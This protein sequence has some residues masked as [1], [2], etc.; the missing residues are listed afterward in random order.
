MSQSMTQEDAGPQSRPWHTTDPD[1][2]VGRGHPVGDFMEAYDWK[3]VEE[4]LGFLRIQV[5]LPEQVKNP[6]GELFGGFA[7]TYVDFIALHAVRAG[8]R[9]TWPNVWLATANMRVDYFAPV[10]DEP[11]FIEAEE[12]HHRSRTHH[13]QVRFLGAEDAMLAVA[14]VTLIERRDATA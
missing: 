4:R 1:R 12:L 8:R 10:K 14:Q 2:V 3:I 11:L 5:H 7:P 13:V 9:E 6:R